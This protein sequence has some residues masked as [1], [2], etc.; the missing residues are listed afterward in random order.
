MRLIP[1]T[2]LVTRHITRV[3]KF[4]IERARTSSFSSHC[5][6]RIRAT[7]DKASH[8][9][10]EQ[11]DLTVS[12]QVAGVDVDIV[13]VLA[14]VVVTVG[15]A[16]VLVVVVVTVGIVVV[17]GCC[18]CCLVAVVVAVMAAD[19]RCIKGCLLCAQKT[20]TSQQLTCVRKQ[21]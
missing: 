12:A 17:L 7:L 3:S 5:S 11:L 19:A 20:Q 16:V 21:P 8:G 14:V 10:F 9:L 6:L 2:L 4:K 13:V 1:H 15:I 18:G